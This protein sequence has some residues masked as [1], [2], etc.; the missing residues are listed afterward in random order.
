MLNRTQRL[1]SMTTAIVIA[2]ASLAAAEPSAELIAAAKK[3]GTLTT[4][5]LPHN[6]CGYGDLIA[7]FKAKYGIEVNELNP[8]A[9]SGDEIEAIKANKGNTGPQAPD[10]IDVGLSFGPSAKAEGLLMPYKVSTWDT[11]PDTAK[12]PEG[13]WYGDYY[14]VLSF[15]VN[16]DIVKEL[17]K[18]WADLKKPEF[19]N[20]VALAGDPRAS[21]QA[22]Q[23]VYAAGLAAGEKDAAKA[24][25]AGLSFF[26]GVN[27]AGNF[28][29]VIGKSASLAQGSTPIVIAWDY[30]GLSWRDSLKGNPP[31]EVVVPA[32]GVVAGVYV[33]AISAFAP[34]PNAAKLWMEFLYS[35]EGQLGWLKGYC[36]P[37]RFNDLAKNN[38]IPKELLDALPPA[39]AYEKAVFP[40]LAEQEAGKT[41][42]TTKWDSVVGANVQ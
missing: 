39:A 15:V 22:V 14:G 21:N 34:H 37:I 36:H 31:L 30:N 42:I 28:V 32:S 5:A 29:P 8:D 33:Q 23:A 1:L 20:A 18:D 4:I 27:K 16:T 38:K 41:A 17:P 13:H 11:I 10:V 9:G 12:D 6:W 3:E 40:T 2:S 24:G 7:A 26:A 19:A 35:D 25:E